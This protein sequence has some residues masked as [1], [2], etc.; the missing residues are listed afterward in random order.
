MTDAAGYSERQNTGQGGNPEPVS[1][2]ESF[3]YLV[4]VGVSAPSRMVTLGTDPMAT[5]LNV[6]PSC[7][8][9]NAPP[10][11][12]SPC[13][14][15]GY[16]PRPPRP[17]PDSVPVQLKLSRAT[18]LRQ[19][20]R[21]LIEESNL[22]QG[23]FG[24]CVFGVDETTICSYLAG[25]KIPNK[26]ERQINQ[27]EQ[28]IVKGGALLVISSFQYNP[29]WNFHLKARARDRQTSCRRKRLRYRNRFIGSPAQYHLEKY[30][31]YY[32]NATL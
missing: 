27:I 14:R 13:P 11:L 18:A 5:T 16:A 6:A 10:S 1:V 32:Q 4:R 21:R 31:E 17:C 22:P 20:L 25:G 19:K 12:T 29:R 26:R 30:A 28:V 23:V 8:A 24:A 2:E 9:D 7:C 3:I 15:C